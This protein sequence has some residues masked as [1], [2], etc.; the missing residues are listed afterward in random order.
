[1]EETSGSIPQK[2][3]IKKESAPLGVPVTAW[4]LRNPPRKHGVAGSIPCLAQQVK[5]PALQCAVL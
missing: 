4:W 2:L 5:D 3:V 1:M